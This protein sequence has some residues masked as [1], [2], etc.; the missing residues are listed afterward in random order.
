[1]PRRPEVV[2]AARDGAG[3]RVL[4]TSSEGLGVNWRCNEGRG[5]CC[6]HCKMQTWVLGT[7]SGGQPRAGGRESA[8]QARECASGTGR[9]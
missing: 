8:T 1:M 5:G 9:G 4:P 3:M 2:Q 7:Q 6:V